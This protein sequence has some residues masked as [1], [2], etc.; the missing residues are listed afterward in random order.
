MCSQWRWGISLKI[1]LKPLELQNSAFQKSLQNQFEPDTDGKALYCDH[2]KNSPRFLDE[3]KPI[4]F[5]YQQVKD[6]R[7]L[8][9]IITM[10]QLF[11]ICTF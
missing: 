6:F 4:P 11:S 2:T 1:L 3:V 10:I 8:M 9:F 7:I 5:V